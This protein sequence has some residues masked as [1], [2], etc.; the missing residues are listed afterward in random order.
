VD[1][2]ILENLDL[3]LLDFKRSL[4]SLLMLMLVVNLVFLI[5]YFLFMEITV[6][7]S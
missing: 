1:S 6:G 2:L 7:T 3:E 4:V 5:K